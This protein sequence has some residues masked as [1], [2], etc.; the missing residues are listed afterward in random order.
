MDDE[1]FFDQSS[2]NRDECS[3]DDYYDEEEE[4]HLLCE[5]CHKVYPCSV[6]QEHLHK[7]GYRSQQEAV[8]R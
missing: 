7:C 4:E 8:I 5:V 2:C 1:Q 6:F 3:S